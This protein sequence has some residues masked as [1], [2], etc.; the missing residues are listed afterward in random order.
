M[1]L[2]LYSACQHPA[3]ARDESADANAEVAAER[4]HFA[5]EFCGV[6]P[7]QGKKFKERARKALPDVHDFEQRWEKGWK[8]EEHDASALRALRDGDPAEFS[9]RVKSS[10]SRIRW[11]AENSVRAHPQK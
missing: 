11:Q 3:L 9:T 7:E 2:V 5:Q 4:V 10:C 6:S 8:R 1:V